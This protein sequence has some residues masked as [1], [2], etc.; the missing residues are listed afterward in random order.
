MP[1][2]WLVYWRKDQI[3]AAVSDRLLDHAASEQFVNVR[4]GDSL[5]ISGQGKTAA[6]VTVGPLEVLDVVGQKEAERRL[7][8]EP[9]KARYHAMVAPGA[10]TA[11]REV[12]LE[13]VIDELRFVSKQRPRL[14]PTKPL[15]NQLQRIRHLT[16]PSAD[17]LRR[18]WAGR[19]ASAASEYDDIQSRL[20]QFDKLD[21]RVTVWRRREQSFLREY[22]FGS[23]D[24]GACAI[25]GA[26]L[27]TALLIAAHIKPRS[28]CTDAERRDF[29]N[30]V[31]PMC[32]L[33][34]DALFESSFLVVDEGKVRVQMD[35]G[36]SVR[37]RVLLKDLDGRS[38]SAWKPGRFQY[39][40][41]H[42][43]Q[44]GRT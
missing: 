9:W 11:S 31:V 17:L 2:Q 1:N 14:D 43:N 24:S 38:T 15:G 25:C 3:E 6:L 13:S 22:L 33:G 30:N 26:M 44:R 7:S 8:Y 36:V 35:A 4:P 29:V 16:K 27:P 42:A 12:S 39:F 32:L 37:L 21:E 5:W 28:Q 19:V 41:W 40:R 10:E 18:L 20:E 23:G 34:C